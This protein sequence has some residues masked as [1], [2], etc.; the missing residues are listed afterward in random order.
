MVR[1][2]LKLEKW[3][4]KVIFT[5]KSGKSEEGRK[6]GYAMHVCWQDGKEVDY[7]VI[8][9]FA[10][11]RRDASQICKHIEK[12]VIDIAL[13]EEIEKKD[14]EGLGL[15]ASL[16]T[17]VVEIV[18]EVRRKYLA[19]EYSLEQMSFPAAARQAFKDY[20][21]QPAFVR[22]ILFFNQ[23]IAPKVG[24][25]AVEPGD[26]VNIIYIKHMA[27]YPPTD[28]IAFV[29]PEDLPPVKVDLRRMFKRE[30][31]GKVEKKLKVLGIPWSQV[32]GQMSLVEFQ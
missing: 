9:G 20:D 21:P 8:K 14:R 7:N 1:L 10:Y 12:A 22:G 5:E 17:D 32:L 27:G 16:K 23:H 29:E 28:V 3:C 26:T 15:G 19:G 24:R 11:V 30:V 2:G 13:T 6:K 18:R 25:P 4:D 31:R